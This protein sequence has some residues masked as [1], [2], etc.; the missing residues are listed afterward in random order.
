MQ[1]SVFQLEGV[2]KKSLL[3]LLLGV[4]LYFGSVQEV[5]AFGSGVDLLENCLFFFTGSKAK[6]SV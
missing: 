5:K 1:E 4:V 3:G 2:M 6:K